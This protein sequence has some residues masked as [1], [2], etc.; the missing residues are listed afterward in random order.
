MSK[1]IAKV[2][3]LG[4]Q[5][6]VAH[7]NA[8]NWDFIYE[9]STVKNPNYNI[10]DRVVLP[11][12]REFH[13]AK[14]SAACN[15]GQGCEFT[16]TGVLAW[17][18]VS[19]SKAIGDNEIAITAGTHNALTEDELRGGYV[20]IY[21]DAGATENYTT[22]RGIIGNIA[23]AADA[24]FTI[25]LDGGLTYALT[26]S[27]SVVEIFANPYAAL[28]TGTED[29][30]PKAG[31]PATYVSAASKYFWVQT[32][33]FGR[34]S[35]QVGVGDA[36]GQKGA[37]WRHDGSLDKADTAL[38][39]TVPDGSSSQYAGYCVAGSQSG[40]GPLFMLQG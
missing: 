4:E 7:T 40:N 6:L 20:I 18:T 32:K 37:F 11:D 39:T 8:P 19:A 34:V 29:T 17:T 25:Y 31:V 15:A 12:G 10:G 28:R 26:A 27:T 2:T 24:A 30:Y 16:D 23:A 3:N 1:G 38:A 9:V 13:Y 5:G 14:S 35:P 22:V 33:G 36:Q 21:P